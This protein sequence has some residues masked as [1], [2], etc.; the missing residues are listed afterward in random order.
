MCDLS[1]D[2]T[3]I[4]IASLNLIFNSLIKYLVST[5]KKKACLH[6]NSLNSHYANVIYLITGH[7]CYLQYVFETV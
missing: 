5:T 1:T 7:D 4:K 3:V 6:T 2:L